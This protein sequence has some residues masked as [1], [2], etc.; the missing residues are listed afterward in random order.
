MK[1]TLLIRSLIIVTYV[2]IFIAFVTMFAFKSS[3]GQNVNTAQLISKADN[4]V[5]SN[6][7]VYALNELCWE[8]RIGNAN[9]AIEYGEKALKCAEDIKFYNGFLT[10]CTNLAYIYTQK[11][12][13]DVALDYYNKG[14]KSI[15]KISD[16]KKRKVGTARIYEGLGLINYL[17]H[18]NEEAIYSYQK[19]LKIYRE[20][21]QRNNTAI[22]YH[23]IGKIY[24][25]TGDKTKASESFYRELQCGNKANYLN[26]S[27]SS[28]DDFESASED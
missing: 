3:Y 26:E 14:L 16:A 20:T 5:K 1:K 17:K 12:K 8:N 28:F 13:F 2:I 27:I 18:E 4:P 9:K 25:K 22:C 11:G 7:K 15:E 24:E 21:A 6:D 19:A 23:I 10:A